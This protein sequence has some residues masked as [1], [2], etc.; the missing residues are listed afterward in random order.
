MN[1]V[2]CI[3]GSVMFRYIWI[4]LCCVAEIRFSEGERLPV[5]GR[6]AA[7]GDDGGARGHVAGLR[8]DQVHLASQRRGPQERL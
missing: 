7:D 8:R 2:A 3:D 5:A 4:L 1:P 6:G